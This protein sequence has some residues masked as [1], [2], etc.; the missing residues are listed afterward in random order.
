MKEVKNEKE[1]EEIKEEEKKPMSND[2]ALDVQI[3][4]LKSP[5]GLYIIFKT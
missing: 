2:E 4:Y 1:K 5:I 3:N